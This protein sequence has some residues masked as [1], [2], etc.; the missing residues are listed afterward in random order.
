MTTNLCQPNGKASLL[1]GETTRRRRARQG[2]NEIL[3][4][5]VIA[6]IFTPLIV[7]TFVTG[8]NVIRSNQANFIARDLADMYI[9]GADFSSYAMQTVAQRLSTGLGLQ[10]GSSFTGSQYANTANSGTGLVTITQLMYVGSTTDTQCVRVGAS[11]CTNHDSFVFT[12]QIQFG[13]GTLSSEQP[14]TFGSPTATRST[15]GTISTDSVTDAGAKL[16]TTQQA[17]M[18][19]LWQ[20]TT[21]GRTHLV[22][23]QILYVAEVY[24]QSPDLQVGSLQGRGVYSR[25]FF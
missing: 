17:A 5:A 13:N 2:G 22:D 23:G 10:I 24:F 16:A 8:M 9:H 21:N 4:F 19:A 7:G 11:N 12:Q 3:E 18:Q 25:W 6:L 14:S 20:V 15:T 1:S